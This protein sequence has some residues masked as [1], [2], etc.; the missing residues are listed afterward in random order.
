MSLLRFQFLSRLPRH[1]KFEYVPRHPK[2]GK[3]TL[4]GGIKL[5]NAETAKDGASCL[6]ETDEAPHPAFGS[7]R[8]LVRDQHV[9]SMSRIRF[10]LVLNIILIIVIYLLF[11]W[12]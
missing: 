10:L 4:R 3:E 1:R 6:P 7:R 9:T 5:S 11:R 8:S 2:P 12:I